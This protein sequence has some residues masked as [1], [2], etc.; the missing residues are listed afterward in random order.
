MK[1]YNHFA[2]FVLCLLTACDS[3]KEKQ[4][5]TEDKAHY[6]NLIRN[7]ALNALLSKP[8]YDPIYPT[9]YWNIDTT[10]LI[11]IKKEVISPTLGIKMRLH[12]WQHAYARM[13]DYII[14]I[15]FGDGSEFAFPFMAHKAFSNHILWAQEIPDREQFYNYIQYVSFKAKLKDRNAQE[16]FVKLFADSLFGLKEI[17]VKDT[18]LLKHARAKYDSDQMIYN[19]C[20]HTAYTDSLIS[21]I[22]R[23]TR[24]IK[25]S[26][27]HTRYYY[28]PKMGTS[29]F[30]KFTM[31]K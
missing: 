19:K 27:H 7:T 29:V 30:W 12:E 24:D 18:S 31:K 1:R 10:T 17:T 28:M 2:I 5:V 22:N 21:R 14:Y 15:A 3:V 11:K 20:T 8:N 16:K 4:A 9:Y 13:H 25:T 6:N 23:M 26:Q